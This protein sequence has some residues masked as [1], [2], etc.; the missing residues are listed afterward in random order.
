VKIHND[1]REGIYK[2]K[3][4]GVSDQLEKVMDVKDTQLYIA[5]SK[6][7]PDDVID[8]WQSPLDEMKADGTFD[9]LVKKYM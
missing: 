9:T 1:Q 4:Q 7:T 2:A 8:K 5:F 3:L 6:N